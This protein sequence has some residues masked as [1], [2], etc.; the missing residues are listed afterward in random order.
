MICKRSLVGNG[1]KFPVEFGK[2][3][4]RVR[5]GVKYRW[6]SSKIVTIASLVSILLTGLG[7]GAYLLYQYHA[8]TEYTVETINEHMFA[9]N[10]N[11]YVFWDGQNPEWEP[12]YPIEAYCDGVNAKIGS[13]EVCFTKRIVVASNVEFLAGVEFTANFSGIRT[14]IG[15]SIPAEFP[16]IPAPENAVIA[17]IVPFEPLDG[18]IYNHFAFAGIGNNSRIEIV[19]RPTAEFEYSGISASAEGPATA[20]AKK[21]SLVVGQEYS[22]QVYAWEEEEVDSA[23]AEAF[24]SAGLQKEAC[25]EECE[26]VFLEDEPVVKTGKRLVE[27]GSFTVPPPLDVVSQTPKS[28]GKNVHVDSVIEL[29]FSKQVSEEGLD[30][31]FSDEILATSGGLKV[32]LLEGTKLKITPIAP[33][34]Y[35]KS[36]SLPIDQTALVGVDGSWVTSPIDISFTTIGAVKVSGVSPGNGAKGVSPNESVKITFDQEVDHA[37]AQ[38]AFSISP[39]ASGSFKWSGN[40]MIFDP[41]SLRLNTTYTITIASGIKSVYGLASTEARTYSFT[42]ADRIVKT[43]GRSVDGR[44]ITAYIYGSGSKTVLFTSGL[45]GNERTSININKSWNSYLHSNP[46]VLPEGVRAIVIEVGNPDG[47]ARLRRFNENGVDINRNWDTSNWASDI[48]VGS[49]LYRGAGGS[50]PFSEPESTALKKFISNEGVDILIDLH[51]CA[52]GAYGTTRTR[53]AELAA[54]IREL[55]GYTDGAGGWTKYPVTGAMTGWSTDRGIIAV[56]LEVGAGDP[57]SQ[58]KS[59]FKA[60]LT[61]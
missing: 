40:T 58:V 59:A 3:L 17:E 4:E 33:W 25:G 7:V 44:A 38:S 50:S 45:H 55:T 61:F 14:V 29:V 34:G 16:L 12:F 36:Y 60:V 15:K 31:L 21:E 51:C 2:V 22:Y 49:T 47:Y 23:T 18:A 35:E 13:K 5:T 24:R 26:S 54:L 10:F 6:I 30:R 46:D 28:G 41:K 48:Y 37:S 9:I 11:H 20:V 56:T 42:T 27:K 8:E 19:T 32:E 53:S 57:F 43:V 39:D 52:E 1:V